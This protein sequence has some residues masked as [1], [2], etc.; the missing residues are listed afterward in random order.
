MEDRKFLI[1]LHER[2]TEVHGEDALFDYMH[3][4]RD[5]IAE[6]HGDKISQVASR[7]NNLNEL[8]KHLKLV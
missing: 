6:T 5:I 8:K 1:W 7:A 4:L 2:L 3:K